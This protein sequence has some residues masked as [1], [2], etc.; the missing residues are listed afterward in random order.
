MIKGELY[1]NGWDAWLAWGVFMDDASIS[2]LMSPP[3]TKEF[4][5]NTS[6]LEHGTRYITTNPKFKE[7]DLTLSIQL[8]APN[9]AEFYIRY[10]LF[11]K[12]VLATG[13]IN[14]RTKYQPNV[15]YKCVYQ[16]C[17]QYKQYMGKVAKFSLKLTEPN[18]E[19]RDGGEE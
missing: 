8:Y 13:L 15:T 11:C 5:K 19:D 14:I 2:A 16:S 18:P 1:I 4:I 7:R 3:A 9:K 12:Q 17:T 6:R 10:N